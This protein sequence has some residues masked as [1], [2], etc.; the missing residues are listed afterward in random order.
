[1]AGAPT[2]EQL[3]SPGQPLGNDDRILFV[4]TDH[5]ELQRL[6]AEWA[7]R[8]TAEQG[9]PEYV[10]DEDTLEAIAAILMAGAVGVHA[11][12]RRMGLTETPSV[13]IRSV[14]SPPR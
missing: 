13:S 7:R 4:A 8:T 14:F 1:M 11:A 2:Q 3:A 9:L 10:E 12:S 5:G 6:A